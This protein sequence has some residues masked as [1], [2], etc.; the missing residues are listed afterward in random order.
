[1]TKYSL[2]KV[3]PS[4]S[5]VDLQLLSSV[6]TLYLRWVKVRNLGLYNVEDCSCTIDGVPVAV[7][8]GQYTV[9]EFVSALNA[10]MVADVSGGS[11]T[12]DANTQK[13]T[14]NLTGAQDLTARTVGWDRATGFNTDQTITTTEEGDRQVDLTLGCVGVFLSGRGSVKSNIPRLN[15]A[16]IVLPNI[17][18]FEQVY[19]DLDYSFPVDYH[20][21]GKRQVFLRSEYGEINLDRCEVILCF[22][23]EDGN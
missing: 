7:A 18:G 1:M 15:G 14:L 12:F 8:D 21:S 20:M 16:D 13:I 5:E 22:S 2:V 11:A 17:S 19:D 9:T 6:R 23:Y 10:V 3:G 4:A